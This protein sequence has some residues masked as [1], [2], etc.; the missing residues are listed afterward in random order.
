MRG[1]KNRNMYIPITLFVLI[2][3]AFVG[4]EVIN[5][6]LAKITIHE[7]CAKYF[8]DEDGDGD[9]GLIEDDSCQNYPYADGNG[10]SKTL[11]GQNS[12]PPYVNYFDMTVDLVR[13]FIINECN[14]NLQNCIGTNFENEVQF[15]CAFSNNIMTNSFDFI[16]SQFNQNYGI[17]D[18]SLSTFFS[19]NCNAF[20]PGTE[21]IKNMP[22]NGD[23]TTTP[24]P[25][26][27]NGQSDGGGGGGMK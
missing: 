11:T 19:L 8:A 15:Y 2:G 7:E 13:V 10:E 5:E 14:G 18:G 1:E 27:P 16:F 4:V 22:N 24:I 6:P 3:S 21:P 25:D 23:Q 9:R 20:P 17:D 26:N 12:N